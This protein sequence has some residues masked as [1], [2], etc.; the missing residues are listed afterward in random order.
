MVKGFIKHHKLLSVIIVLAALLRFTGA[1]PGYPP[2]HTDEGI[3]HSQG[4][5][6]ILEKT[7]DPKYGY[8]VPYNYPIVVPLINAL[9]YLLFFIPIYTFVY[10][11]VH[12]GDLGNFLAA[13]SFGQIGGIFEYNILGQNKI[14]VVF[15][16]RYITAFFGTAVVFMTY[17]LGKRLFFS[18]TIG[19]LAAFFTAINYRQ[20]LNSHFG[21]PDIYN[22]FFLLISLYLTLLLWEKQTFKRYVLAGTGIAIYF[23]TKFQF[24]ALPPLLLVLI[25]LAEKKKGWHKR[26]KFFLQPQIF[27]LIG[28]GVLAAVILNIFHILH[29]QETLDQVGYSSLKYRY[30]RN[31]LDI[32]SLSYL[33]HIGIGHAASIL[34]L[35]GVLLGI[36]FNFRKMLFLLAVI[37]PFFWMMVYY[38]GGGFYTRN[39]VT[40]T[41]L[42]L[43]CEAFA[44]WQIF[45][46]LK[47]YSPNLAILLS[48]VLI[49]LVS[50]QSLKNS[51]L[52]PL[53]YSKSW[54]YTQAQLWL[55]KNLP[56]KAIVLTDASMVLPQKDLQI[57]KAQ[58]V[59]DYSLVELQKKGVEWV[60]INTDWFNGEFLWWMQVDTKNGLK[61]WNKPTNLLLSS[62]TTKTILELK[63]Y[64]V[65][66]ALNP[67]QAPDNNYLVVRIPQKD[68]KERFSYIKSKFNPEEHLFLNSN[69][70]M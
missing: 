15:W 36:L 24:F 35:A 20:V 31:M 13:A 70:G 51:Y 5:A 68:K 29:W 61:Y 40:I 19:L 66:E 58:S 3:T 7:L 8:G 48:S 21:L 10:L 6:M 46:L 2:I 41:P 69:G 22:T 17:L 1:S 27:F 50:Y 60:V 28:G 18:I 57:I 11:L 16:G 4:I 38:T 49:L 52:V 33:Y 42:L 14:N 9:F 47:K 53:E 56:R 30:G 43:I 65:F 34:V 55:S 12:F 62:P 63:D 26:F 23:S 59:N 32:Y 54:N 25:F 67:W 39:F 37:I 45:K 64:V 44:V